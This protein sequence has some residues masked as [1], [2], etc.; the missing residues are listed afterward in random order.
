[1]VST[2]AVPNSV[3][4]S[5]YVAP[6]P[7]RRLRRQMPAPGDHRACR[8]PH[9]SAR[10]GHRCGRGPGR[11]VCVPTA[12]CR[13]TSASPRRARIRL[14]ATRFRAP[15]RMSAQVNSTVEATVP[16]VVLTWIPRPAAGV[17]VDRCVERT[18]GG[19]HLQP[20]QPI[21]HARVNGVRSRITITTSNGSSRATTSSSCATWSVKT[22]ISARAATGDQSAICSATFW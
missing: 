21:E 1:M 6:R 20:G 5:T 14:P 22:V 19:D 18:R 16:P 7:R 17:H 13:L 2:S 4:R 3:S 15:A 9:R 8:T 12:H 11:R 10:R